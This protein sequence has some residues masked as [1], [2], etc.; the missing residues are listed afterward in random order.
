MNKNE[1]AACVV[2]YQ[3]DEQLFKNITSYCEFI[4]RVFVID[5]SD[6]P[7]D[8][9]VLQ[10]QYPSIQYVFKGGNIGIATALNEAVAMARAEGFEWILTMDQDSSFAPGALSLYLTAATALDCS[11]VGIITLHHHMGEE[12]ASHQE[13]EQINSTMTSGN[14]LNIECHLET[15]GFLDKFFIDY[16]D[17]EFCLRIRKQGYAI[18]QN[19][20]VNLMHQLG[21]LKVK[22]IFGLSIPYTNHHPIRR[23][24]ITRNRLYVI[25][26]Y[27]S[28]SPSSSLAELSHMINEGIKIVLFEKDKLKKAKSIILGIK[29]FIFSKFGK[30]PY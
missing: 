5:N 18:W 15:G 22:K 30:Y 27:F 1:I 19:N 2:L 14:L 21:A 10:A 23:Y 9:S 8:M 17:H 28:F 12:N 4:S 29:D 25:F 7:T 11:G 26:K 3:P 16:V 13:W 20:R 6:V 24:Y